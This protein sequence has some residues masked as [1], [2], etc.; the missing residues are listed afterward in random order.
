MGKSIRVLSMLL[1]VIMGLSLLG[2]SNT[3]GTPATVATTVK[4][5]L[6]D[7]DK[8][9]VIYVWNEEFK[10]M[11]E[12]YY[13]K[14]HPLPTGYTYEF[15]IN[16]NQNNVYQNKLD[17]ALLAQGTAAVGKKIDIFLVEAD[18]ALKYVDSDYTKDVKTLG[19]T[20]ADL[21]N[22]YKYTQAIATDSKG[23]LKGLSWQ[24][25]PGLF[26]YRRSIAKTVFG[27]DDPAAIQ[28]LLSDWDKFDAA[29]AKVKEKT[30]GAV[31]MLSGFDDSYR[32]FSNNVAKPW[33][34]AKKVIQIDANI[35]K[36]VEQT[37]KYT[38]SSYNAKTILWNDAWTQGQTSS[39]KVFGYFYSTWGINFTLLGN[40]LDKKE[41]DGGK[42][43]V[44]NGIF[45]DWAVCPGPQS[46][47]WGG[48]WIC[49]SSTGNTDALVADVMRY[50][51]VDTAAMKAY[52]LA[53]QDFVN[54]KESIKAIT[55]AGYSS[56]FLGGQDH[57][58]LFAAAADKINL[59]NITPYDQGCNECFQ[60]A[61]HDYFNGTVSKDKALENFYTAVITRYPDLKK[62]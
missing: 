17:E 55:T 4:K 44:G 2:C 9:L 35:M 26:A 36:W 61:F 27:T 50:F 34:D 45:G 37:K 39:G 52:S 11:F 30:S 40:S 5:V 57:I 10:G 46:Y 43:V 23:I 25:T 48:T 47:Y 32:T 19:F 51:T 8:N 22:Q 54:N 6:A 1:V 33:V 28:A 31:T 56:A 60:T 18:Y 13:L 3:T 41:A 15:V 12:K 53:S 7:A 42:Q 62:S 21:A 38:D 14:D 29:A 24:A 59:S 49:A 16:P 20:T 58:S